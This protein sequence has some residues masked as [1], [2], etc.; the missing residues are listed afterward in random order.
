M[1]ICSLCY[2]TIKTTV[3]VCPRCQKRAYC[4]ED[5]RQRDWSAEADPRGQGHEHFCGLAGER[6]HDFDVRLISES[7]GMGMVALRDIKRHECIAVDNALVLRHFLND[8]RTAC[9]Q[10]MPDGDRSD[11]FSLNEMGS[12]TG[13]LLQPRK[14]LSHGSSDSSAA[15]SSPL[16]LL[17]VS[18][19]N[20]LRKIALPGVVGLLVARL[21]HSCLANATH[22][23]ESARSAKMIVACKD[24]CAG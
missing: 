3:V 17:P 9:D 11:K 15:Y 19:K 12:G 16:L 24:I 5:C 13:E 14:G 4:S 10:L 22:W 23:Y 1:S 20:R 21:N 8:P 7:K 18:G 2:E 6:G